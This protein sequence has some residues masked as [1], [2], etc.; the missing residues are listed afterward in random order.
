MQ[1]EI[2]LH[3]HR[4]QPIGSQSAPMVDVHIETEVPY[5]DSLDHARALYLAD[6][7]RLVD[8]LYASLPGGTLDALLYVLLERKASLLAVSYEV[9]V[10]PTP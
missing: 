3:L 9:S 6:A 1:P 8:A 5:I 10:T 7:L 2:I 4:A